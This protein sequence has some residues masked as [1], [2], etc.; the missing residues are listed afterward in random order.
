MILSLTGLPGAG[1]STI[2][3]LLSEKLQMP[4]Y[5]IGA[6]RGK[7]A[8]ERGITID[9]LNHI[10]E[11]HAFTDQEVDDY[12]TTL[13][14]TQDHFIVDGRLAW[15]FIPHSYKIFL[16]VDSAVAAERIFLAAKAGLR[17][18]EKP[19]ASVKEVEEAITKRLASDQK[20]YEQYYQVD[21][22][23]RKNYDIVID[24]TRLA[25]DEIVNH[26]LKKVGL[27]TKNP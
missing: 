2:A 14:K 15:H 12:Q 17:P 21:Y 3:K 25:P 7:M 18:D 26:I 19:Y 23:D 24:T 27:L 4:W 10:G 1:K 9:E 20:R 13:G 22:L 16:D 5:S 11:K 6:L 8:E